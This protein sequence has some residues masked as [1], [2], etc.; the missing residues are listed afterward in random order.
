MAIVI[1]VFALTFMTLLKVALTL[2]GGLAGAAAFFLMCISLAASLSSGDA[3][4]GL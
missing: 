1:H 4:R 3:P 2:L